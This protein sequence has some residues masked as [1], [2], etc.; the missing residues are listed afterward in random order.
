M[1]PREKAVRAHLK[2][3]TAL[4]AELH[5]EE[6]VTAWEAHD[7]NG[8]TVTTAE[9]TYTADKLIV[10]A[11]AWAPRALADLSLPLKI[12]RQVLYW[13][14]PGNGYAEFEQGRFPI[15]VFEL[16][17][18][19]EFYGF[20]RQNEPGTPPGVKVAYFYRDTPIGPDNPRRIVTPEETEA[21]R[22]ALRPRIPNLPGKLLHA[23]TCLYTETPRPS[24]PDRFASRTQKRGSGVAL[25][26]A[27][28]QILQR[29]R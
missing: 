25:L 20:P 10:S 23:A 14:E 2:R 24:L 26:R 28:F 5:F 1:S 12:T 4:G 16:P 22:E 27:W 9:G 13:F 11:G 7:E 29:R 6:P 19:D 18:G 21:M 17:N 3:A 8:V 15:Y